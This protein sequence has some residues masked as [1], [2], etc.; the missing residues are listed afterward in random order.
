MRTLT[1]YLLA[2]HIRAHK[3][4][5]L[6]KLTLISPVNFEINKYKWAFASRIIIFDICPAQLWARI[7]VQVTIYRNLYDNTRP[8]YGLCW[9]E[10]QSCYCTIFNTNHN[11]CT[12]G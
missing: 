3:Y 10:D 7:I 6:K 2:T 12:G 11:D 9:A 4:F 1:L 5:T 8:G